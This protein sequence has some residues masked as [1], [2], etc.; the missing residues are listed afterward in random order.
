M[1]VLVLHAAHNCLWRN[2]HCSP[3]HIFRLSH[4]CGNSVFDIPQMWQPY[5]RHIALAL[6]V[7]PK[8]RCCCLHDNL[9]I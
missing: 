4:A 1:L 2:G 5:L 7:M 6:H 3:V 9:C 8:C